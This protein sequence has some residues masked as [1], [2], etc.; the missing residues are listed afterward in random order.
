MST[1]PTSLSS[2]RYLVYVG[3][4][5]KGIYGFH[6][7]TDGSLTPLGLV[8]EI[9][10]PS[11]IATDIQHRFLYAVSELEGEKEGGAGAFVINSQTGK[12]QA[13]N[14]VSSF[15]VAP[16]HLAVDRTARFLA[17]ANYMSGNVA[18]FHLEDDGRI[19]EL[20]CLIAGKGGSVNAERQAGP[21]AHQVVFGGDD[22]FLYVPD[23][24][25]D[26]IR[27]YDVA[28]GEGK[29]TEHNSAVRE[30][31]GMGPRHLALSADGRFA[32]LFNEL[33]S[34]VTVY[35]VD[36][37][38]NF[39]RV[40]EISS[41][42]PNTSNRDGGAE[43]LVHPGG[44]FVYAS[45]RG[46]GT[47]AVFKRDGAEG[48]LELVEIAKVKGTFPRGMQFDP[49]GAVLLVGDQKENRISVLRVN[50][51]SGVLSDTGKSYEVASPV[52]FVFVSVSKD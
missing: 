14:T 30:S 7:E 18:G 44:K 11:W 33:K 38:A 50:L 48:T 12:L 45:N 16:C 10:N 2:S 52:A 29:L 9:A 41:L 4:Y 20:T 31:P 34:Y 22:R 5:G 42:P 46:P 26:Q 8:G 28:I 23:L 21:H 15:G 47:I 1:S 6:Y 32:Y 39:R 51:E 19:G 35:H 27:L 17:V 36:E 3:T 25:A 49:S 13:L 43:I 24:G 40:Q 37:A